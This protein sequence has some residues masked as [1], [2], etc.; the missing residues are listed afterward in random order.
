LAMAAQQAFSKY[1]WKNALTY[2]QALRKMDPLSQNSHKAA[3]CHVSTL[4]QLRQKRS[5]FRLAH[6]WVEAAPKEA[7]SWF[8]VG[9]YYYACQRYHM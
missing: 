6:E 3:F 7:R 2:C 9:A 1:D 5:L 4:V 8:A